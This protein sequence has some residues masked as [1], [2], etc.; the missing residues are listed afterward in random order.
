MKEENFDPSTSSGSNLSDNRRFEKLV[1]QALKELHKD[2]FKKMENV[3]IVIEKRPSPD[4]LRKTGIRSGNLLLGLYQ[5]IPK[6]QWGR[7]FGNILPD[8]ITIF[9]EPIEFLGRSTEG[10]LDILKNTIF[11]EILHHFGFDE[12]RLREL[13]RKKSKN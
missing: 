1:Q 3:A 4:Q 5:G 2:I 11:H 12:K 13:E 7:G 10:I 8:K 9:Q 6:T